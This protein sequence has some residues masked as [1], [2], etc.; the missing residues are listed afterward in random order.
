M[1]NDMNSVNCRVMIVH[2]SKTLDKVFLL[3]E[4]SK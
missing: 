1:G 4:Y 2:V 3:E